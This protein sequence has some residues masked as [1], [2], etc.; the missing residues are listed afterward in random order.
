MHREL[1]R[2]VPECSLLCTVDGETHPVQPKWQTCDIDG[3][4]VQFWR[5]SLCRCA[6]CAASLNLHQTLTTFFSKMA[7]HCLKRHLKNFSCSAPCRE[8]DEQ[9]VPDG[10]DDKVVQVFHGV[11]KIMT[12]YTVGR[13]PKAM[14]IIPSLQNWEEV[15]FLTEPEMWS[16]HAVYQATRIFVSNLNQKMVGAGVSNMG[17][18]CCLTAA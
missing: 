18:V 2:G 1:E 13:V 6:L 5:M 10:L 14:K 11:G 9:P 3:V 17:P 4:V 8:D 12:R 15:L 16:P 7:K